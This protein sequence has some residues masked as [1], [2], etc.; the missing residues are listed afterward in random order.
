MTD[1]IELSPAQLTALSKFEGVR[2]LTSTSLCK[3]LRCDKAVGNHFMSVLFNSGFLR[4]LGS[5]EYYLTKNGLQY[6]RDKKVPA[7]TPYKPTKDELK[8]MDPGDLSIMNSSKK[9]AAVDVQPEPEPYVDPY[10]MPP[11]EKIDQVN[12]AAIEAANVARSLN[13]LAEKLA[14]KPVSI[15]RMQLKLDVLTQL[16]KILDAEIGAVLIEVSEDLIAVGETPC[17]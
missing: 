5:Y 15:R 8:E 14:T 10:D 6:L 2:A 7:K 3:L 16:S 17:A 11:A 1:K 4:K 12:N 13:K 9:P